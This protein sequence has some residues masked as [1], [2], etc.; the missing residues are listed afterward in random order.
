MSDPSGNTTFSYDGKGRLVQ[1]TS[2]ILGQKYTFGQTYTPGGRLATL[3]YPVGRTVD[4]TRDSMGRMQGLSTTFN[5]N[6][7]NLVSNMTYNPFS[8]PN[9]LST[10]AGGVVFN[11][12]GECDCIEVANPG[13]QMERTYSYDSNRNLT[14]ITA[15]NIPWYNQTFTY[16]ALNRL[17]YASGRYGVISYT[18]DNGGNRLSRSLNGEVENL[19][20]IQGTNRLH[21]ITGV[22]FTP[23]TYDANGNTTVIGDRVLVY[24]QNNRLIRVERNGTV[25][26]EYIYNGLGQRVIK[27]VDGVT[28]VFHYDFDGKVIAESLP[29]GTLTAEYFYMGKIRIAKVEVGNGK[30]YYYLNDRLGTPQIM[31]DDNGNVVWEASYKP[32]GQ[33]SVNTKSSVTNNFRFPGQYHDQETGFHYNYHRYY[34]P[35]TGRY[36]TPDPIGLIGGINLFAYVENNPINWIDPIGLYC[37]IIWEEGGTFHISFRRGQ[38]RIGYWQAFIA[39]T[40]AQTV[41]LFL[42]KR[43]PI[44]PNPV[45]EKLYEY[46][47]VFSIYET[48][49]IYRSYYEICYDDCTGEETSK[50]FI[51][52]VKSKN[53]QEVIYETWTEIRRIN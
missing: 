46:K 34:D 25:L 18:Y 8:G 44:P 10:G 42:P 19:S 9:G 40:G 37:K 50:T 51:G 47:I 2:T 1:K 38:E 33:A 22:D 3:M 41:R 17:T 5:T 32:F 20:Y 12:S 49:G 14:S 24:N 15:T 53:R 13:E 29:D 43:F 6:T 35:G 16:D 48:L 21:E 36:L 23:F 31:T 28:T 52:R 30:M 26:G 7:V 45:E 27:E 39:W 11:Q 4:Y